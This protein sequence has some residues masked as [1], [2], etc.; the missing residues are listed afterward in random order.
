MFCL[1]IAYQL[2]IASHFLCV[3]NVTECAATRKQSEQPR[4]GSPVGYPDGNAG[5][6]EAGNLGALLDGVTPLSPPGSTT[7]G[8]NRNSRA[9]EPQ[10]SPCSWTQKGYDPGWENTR[11]AAMCG[12]H[13]ATEGASKDVLLKAT[14][15]ESPGAE[16][17][18]SIPQEYEDLVQVFS[19][20][21]ATQLPPHRD[22]DC[23]ITLQAWCRIYALSQEEER[24]ID[25]NITEALEQGYIHPSTSPAS[26]RVFFVKKKDRSLRPCV[27]YWGLRKLLIPY[28]YPL[29]LVPAALEQLRGARY[30]TKLDLQNAY[31]LIQVREGDEWKTA[32]S[33]SKGHYEYL[34]LPYGLATALSIFQAYI[35]EVLREFLRRSI[36]TYVDDILIYS[37]SW[38]QHVCDV[39]ALDLTAEPA[40][41]Q[42]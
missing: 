2:D 32:F 13:H 30:F 16:K 35:N 17:Q 12:N 39:R 1:I 5:A 24:A 25:Q 36:V 19:P 27:H 3:G 41:L 42:G 26:A 37:S 6:A 21:K 11:K 14:S 29:P 40:I 33:T 15:I 34:V 9:E 20:T 23:A 18:V 38:N 7:T 22:W 31:N 28:L 8:G 4:L 10:R